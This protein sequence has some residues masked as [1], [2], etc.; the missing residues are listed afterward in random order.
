M[1]TKVVVQIIASNSFWKLHE[2]KRIHELTI[3]HIMFTYLIESIT[4]PVLNDL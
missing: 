4:S 2:E 3:W 1:F